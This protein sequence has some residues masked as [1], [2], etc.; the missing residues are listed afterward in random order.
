MNNCVY[1]IHSDSCYP[2][3]DDIGQDHYHSNCSKF[4]IYDSI[5]HYPDKNIIYSNHN[6]LNHIKMDCIF[7]IQQYYNTTKHLNIHDYSDIYNCDEVNSDF[8]KKMINLELKKYNLDHIYRY[9]L[10]HLFKILNNISTLFVIYENY[11]KESKKTISIT[12]FNNL[13]EID[14]E[15]EICTICSEKMTTQN[16]KLRCGHIFHK[17]CIQQWLLNYSNCCP[18]CKKKTN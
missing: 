1:Y 13:E 16:I 4:Y 18:Y 7:T 14:T 17:K 11:G 9:D 12:D 5:T 15:N 3:L 8:L 6:R 2:Y 10:S